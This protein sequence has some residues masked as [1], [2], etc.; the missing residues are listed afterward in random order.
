M[1]LKIAF[2]VLL[3][4]IFGVFAAQAQ[5]INLSVAASMTD[6]F[7]EMITDF[8][9]QHTGAQFLRNFASSG[10][11]AKQIEQGAPTDIFVSANPKWIKYLLE[12]QL[13]AADS[14]RVFAYN[15]L[16]F[17]G[18]KELTGLSLPGLTG[19]D[20][21]ALGTPQSVP[22]GQYAKQAMEH[23]G[24]YA[25]LEEARK[26]VMAKDVR[27]ALIYADRGEV[28]GSFVYKTDALLAKNAEI[29]FVVPEDHYD[30]VSYFV[31]LTEKGAQ[32][33]MAR[34]FYEYIESPEATAI[35]TRL[36]FVPAR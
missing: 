15:Q 1:K 7:N 24:V 18:M 2:T 26:L 3:L 10:N 22:A 28:D 6:A 35:L 12:K 20:R 36:G 11:L 14:D 31:A 5:T 19:L 34:A 16:V 4:Q 8:S 9:V 13:I 30:R 25:S 17:I 27:Q 23:A 29:L 33:D 32:N 21:V